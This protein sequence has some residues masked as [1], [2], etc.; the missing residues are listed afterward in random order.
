M[1]WIIGVVVAVII[2]FVAWQIWELIHAPI[3]DDAFAS[4][5]LNDDEENKSEDVANN[6]QNS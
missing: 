4:F 3:V 6:Q 5:I 2:A 1:L